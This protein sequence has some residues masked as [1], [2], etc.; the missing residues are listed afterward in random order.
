M[1]SRNLFRKYYSLGPANLHIGGQ[2]TNI[3]GLPIVFDSGSTYT[4]FSSHAYN[5]LVSLVSFLFWIID[6][7]VY[8]ILLCLNGLTEL[9]FTDKKQLK[10]EA[11]KRCSQ[12]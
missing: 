9:L 5:A 10:W 6:D 4:Y 8:V 11:T 7:L 2:A 3:K 12:W 1:L